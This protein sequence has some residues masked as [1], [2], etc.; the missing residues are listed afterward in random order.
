MKKL[1]AL[2][3]VLVMVFTFAACGTQNGEDVQ[4]QAAFEEV[5]GVTIPAF[6]VYV[7]GNPV[8]NDDMAAYPIYSIQVTTT[9]SSG[10][11]T[12]PTYIGFKMTDVME[13][14]QLTDAYIY[15]TAIADDGYAVEF[16]D[17]ADFSNMM[18]GISKDGTQFKALPWF[19][20]CDSATTGDYL[21]GCENILFN[22]TNEKPEIETQKA[23]VQEGEYAGPDKQ[24]KTDKVEFGDFSFKVNGNDVTNADLEGLSI[25]KVTAQATNSKGVTS[26]ATYTGYVLA[27]VLAAAGVTDYS[28]VFA[29]ANDGYE[30]ELTLEQAQSEYTI[31]AI[32]KDKETGEDGTI[33]VAPCE[34]TSSGKYSKLVVEIKAE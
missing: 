13:A 6:T 3:L 11:T 17:V 19:C 15:V 32:E 28:K 26:E 24:D 27:D 29:V 34:E 16:T 8:T 23:D 22:T 31:V 21:Q 4:E 10:T 7:N 14:A 18:L 2:L 33:W 12:T 25:F 5:K 20:P 1:L 30:N 9:N